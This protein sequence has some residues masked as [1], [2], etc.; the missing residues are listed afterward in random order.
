MDDILTKCKRKV[1]VNNLNFKRNNGKKIE[2][3][4]VIIG[5]EIDITNPN[6]IE[7]ITKLFSSTVPIITK[8]NYYKNG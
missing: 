6:D 3:E 5:D 4:Y 8:L 7:E 1:D 2:K